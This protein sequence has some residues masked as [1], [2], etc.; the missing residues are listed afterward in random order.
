MHA[1]PKAYYKTDAKSEGT[2]KKSNLVKE[3]T[4]ASGDGISSQSRNNQILVRPLSSRTED[5]V[6]SLVSIQDYHA[7]SSSQSLQA[8]PHQTKE[9]PQDKDLIFLAEAEDTPSS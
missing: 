7:V 5:N 6:S 2:S 3:K 1:V 4:F 9:D 8:G